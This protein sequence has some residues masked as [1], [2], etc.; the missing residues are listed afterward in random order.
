MRP[1]EKRGATGA[2]NAKVIPYRYLG[3][4]HDKPIPRTVVDRLARSVGASDF[5]ET[6]TYATGMYGGVLLARLGYTSGFE[7][8]RNLDPKTRKP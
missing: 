2:S 1:S 7:H 3:G 8:W 4:T 6:A 5:R